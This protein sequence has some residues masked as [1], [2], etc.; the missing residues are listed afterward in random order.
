MNNS[1]MKRLILQAIQEEQ[2]DCW[3]Q[4]ELEKIGWIGWENE[5]AELRAL[6]ETTYQKGSFTI[7]KKI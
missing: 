4:Y 3:L 5:S 2:S 1:E 7:I 6:F